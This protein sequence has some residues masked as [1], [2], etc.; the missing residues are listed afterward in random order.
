METGIEVFIGGTVLLFLCFLAVSV[1]RRKED[2]T[3]P[4]YKNISLM[5]KNLSACKVSTRQTVLTELHEDPNWSD[6]EV[7]ELKSVLEGM[8]NTRIII[9]SSVTKASLTARSVK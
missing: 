5:A 3:K 4:N 9:H 8:L 7:H 6:E 1:A 2:T